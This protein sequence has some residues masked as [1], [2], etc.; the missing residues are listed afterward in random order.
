M[1]FIERENTNIFCPNVRFLHSLDASLLYQ[2]VVQKNIIYSLISNNPRITKWCKFA[3][4][5]H[6]QR[7]NTKSNLRQNLYSQVLSIPTPSKTRV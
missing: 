4:L 7:L 6:E 1:M 3:F 2:E 5:K